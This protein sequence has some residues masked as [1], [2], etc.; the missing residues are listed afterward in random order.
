MA[1][2]FVERMEDV[3]NTL[4]MGVSTESRELKETAQ[5][6]RKDQRLAKIY[7]TAA[8]I[9]ARDGYDATSLSD[10]AKAVGLTKAG[11]YHY[12]PSKESLLFGIMNYG[13]DRVRERVI[14]PTQ[15]IADPARRIRTLLANY[16][17]LIIEDGQAVTIIITEP[18]GLAPKQHRIVF[19][20]RRAF[21]EYVRDTI[22]EI[23][24]KGLAP[25]LNVSVTAHSVFGVLLSFAQWYRPDGQLSLR[26]V[27]DQ[28][29]QLTVERMI[30]L[31]LQQRPGG[32]RSETREPVISQEG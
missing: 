14:A 4:S 30:G 11:L 22:Q 24:D 3:V 7:T 21:Y 31:G 19:A 20:R 12:I 32:E 10:I 9:I 16:L 17:S 6:S 1:S 2:V 15:P 26:Q 13:M 28:I 25:V 18:Q 27:I 29:S 23:Q 5:T 8:E